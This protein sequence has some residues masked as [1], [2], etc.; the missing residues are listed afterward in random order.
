MPDSHWRNILH[1]HDEPDEAMQHIDA[2]VAPLEELPDAVRHIR[3]LISRF[4]SL[5]HYRAFD[6][7]D[8]IVRAI[9]EGTYSDR[10]AV[11]VLTRAWEMDDQRRSRAKTYVQTL[12]AWSEGKSAEEAQQVAGDSELC[13]ELYATLGPF[14]EHKAWLA[15]S[16]A[17]TLKAFAYEAQD[18]LDETAEEDFVR[19]VYRA[20][21]DRDPSHDDLQNRL[22]EL[23]GGKS[24]DHFVREVFDSAESRQR[25]QWRV[26][27][28]LHA[29]ENG[30]C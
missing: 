27:E 14:E 11:D 1:H 28:K 21:L 22:A 16:L 17:H 19:G 23:A 8:L 13:V 12:R 25:Q 7:L 9:S 29:D 30:K 26:L 20:A 4:D 2:Q 10:P 3:A 15:A 18:L 24:R 6:N 5:T